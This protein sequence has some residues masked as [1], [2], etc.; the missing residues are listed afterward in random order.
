ML[1][2]V[3]GL[4]SLAENPE[5][6]TLDKHDY[7]LLTETFVYEPSSIHIPTHKLFHGL[8]EKPS[9]GRPKWGVAIGV[10]SREHAKMIKQD[11]KAVTVEIDPCYLICVYSPPGEPVSSIVENIG[12]CLQVC[13][14]KDKHVVV[15]GDFNC[16]LLLDDSRSQAF[17]EAMSELELIIESPL[18][19]PTYVCHNGTSCVDVLMSTA[20]S[21]GDLLRR[22]EIFVSSD[23]KHRPV[24][25]ELCAV[26]EPPPGEGDERR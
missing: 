8:T 14:K 9:K 12:E 13:T 25:F 1:W 4:R 26:R 17:K 20:A 24:G 6:D 22:C 21:R 10:P 5:V 2:N 19:T 7:L 18:T 11:A 3:E 23:R 15:G 16:N